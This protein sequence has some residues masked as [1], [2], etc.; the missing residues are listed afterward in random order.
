MAGRAEWLR[1]VRTRVAR[2]L[3]FELSLAWQ[4]VVGGGASPGR[5]SHDCPPRSRP[6]SPCGSTVGPLRPLSR[7]VQLPALQQAV[8]NTIPRHPPLGVPVRVAGVPVEQGGAGRER[9]GTCASQSD[10]A[11]GEVHPPVGGDQQNPV[12]QTAGS[13]GQESLGARGPVARCPDLAAPGHPIATIG[14]HFHRT[15][16]R[17]GIRLGGPKADGCCSFSCPAESVTTST[18]SSPA[19]GTRSAWGVTEG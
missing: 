3:G 1:E 16:A 19:A 7:A 15:A 14:R 10:A 6:G 5:V 4:F 13:G 12:L 17:T 8:Q 2:V 9:T 11:Q 18:A